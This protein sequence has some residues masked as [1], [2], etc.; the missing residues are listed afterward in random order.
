MDN[1]IMHSQVLERANKSGTPTHGQ[2]IFV[3][4]NRMFTFEDR[5]V[6]FY[7]P[8]LLTMYIYMHDVAEVLHPYLV[9]RWAVKTNPDR[10]I[11]V[12]MLLKVDAELICIK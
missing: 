1:W 7:L 3:A 9:H 4:G 8:Q 12:V 2:I 6:N 10:N 11:V 5:N